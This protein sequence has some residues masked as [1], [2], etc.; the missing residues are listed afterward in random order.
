MWGYV[1]IH[2]CSNPRGLQPFQSS[3][4]A[5]PTPVSDGAKLAASKRTLAHQKLSPSVQHGHEAPSAATRDSFVFRWAHLAMVLR[6]HGFDQR[7]LR[8]GLNDSLQPKSG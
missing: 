8:G 5:R 2:R 6:D 3:V 1:R 7:V 4:S